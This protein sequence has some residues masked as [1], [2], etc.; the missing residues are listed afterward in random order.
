MPRNPDPD[1]IEEVE[2]D[3][4]VYGPLPPHEEHRMLVQLTKK[5]LLSATDHIE[6]SRALLTR[7]D[8]K[9]PGQ[10]GD[11]QDNLSNA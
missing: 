7:M 5:S 2:H 9:V 1:T 11:E 6:D 4:Q 3:D 8:A 10:L